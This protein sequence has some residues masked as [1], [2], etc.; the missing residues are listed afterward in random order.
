MAQVQAPS[1]ELFNY[2]ADARMVV[3]KLND[4]SLKLINVNNISD[5]NLGANAKNTYNSDSTVRLAKV[6][7][8]K[9]I[10]NSKFIPMYA[11]DN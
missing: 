10:N 2:Y 3:L 7:L 1:K 6:Q 4:G 8:R 5:I 11:K 9:E